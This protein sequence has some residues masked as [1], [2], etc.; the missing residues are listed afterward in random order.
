MSKTALGKALAASTT[1]FIAIAIVVKGIKFLMDTFG[2]QVIGP[3][4]I[5]ITIVGFITFGFY[6][7]FER[8]ERYAKS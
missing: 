1:L 8:Q 6:D 3:A 5:I 4:L 7:Y 2:P